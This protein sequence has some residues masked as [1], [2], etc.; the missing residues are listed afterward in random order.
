MT[1]KRIFLKNVAAAAIAM[2][3]GTLAIESSKMS[4]IELHVRLNFFQERLTK[5]G[6]SDLS[7]TVL[8]VD[9]TSQTLEL[10]QGEELLRTYTISTAANGLGSE[11]ESFKTP[12]GIHRIARKIGSGAE[13]NTVFRGRQ[14]TD[15]Y[16]RIELTDID[17]GLDLITS[18]IMRLK[19]EEPGINL[20][21][22]VDSYERYIYIHGT[23]EE[24]RIGQPVSHGCI[25]M[26]NHDVIDLYDRVDEN[27]LVIIN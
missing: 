10:W 2:S 16:A 20:G 21:G 9:S 8:Y 4:N 13:P 25:R 17:T 3:T 7:G 1:D 15:E 22:Q 5:L 11:K 18:R 12:A 27:S 23:N 19:G 26:R 24:G 6:I 14:P